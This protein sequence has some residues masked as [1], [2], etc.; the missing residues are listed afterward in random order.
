MTRRIY[1]AGPEVFLANARDIGAR[2]R[3]ICARHSLVGVYPT[4]E[5]EACEPGQPLRE[6]GLAISSAMECVMRGATP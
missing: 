3:A 5:E 1:L 2:K 4:D 6:R